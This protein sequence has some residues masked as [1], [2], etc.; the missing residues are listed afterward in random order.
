MAAQIE[1]EGRAIREAERKAARG[2]NSEAVI[3]VG[4]QGA[5]KSTFYQ[6]RLA[7]T[8][9]RINLDMLKTRHRERRLLEV[10][11]ETG[12]R[13]VIDNTNPTRASREVYVRAAK[14][15]GFRLICYYF[16]SRIEDCVRRNEL[17]SPEH[18]IPLRGILGTARR[19]EIPSRAEGFDELYY[20]LISEA[21]RFIV[22]EW[23][24]EV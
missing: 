18:Q 2:A 1:A 24:D 9:L 17:R 8:H 12:T 15:A 23:R 3:F 11:L 13:F 21:G 14:D 7:A 20:V 19:M 10:C 5:G 22:E 6:E 4:L 16:Q